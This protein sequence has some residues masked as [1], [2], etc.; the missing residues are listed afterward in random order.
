[1]IHACGKK[2]MRRLSQADHI[3]LPAQE[4]V[5]PQTTVTWHDALAPIFVILEHAAGFGY[6]R[7]WVINALKEHDLEIDPL[8]Y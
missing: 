7:S 6:M 4:I 3:I 2:N 8:D 1:M 5:L